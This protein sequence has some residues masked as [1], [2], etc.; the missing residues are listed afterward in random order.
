MKTSRPYNI[1]TKEVVGKM[2]V[3]EDHVEVKLDIPPILPPEQTQAILAR[4]LAERK[5]TPEGDGTMVRERGGV[6][7]SVDL[8]EEEMTVSAEESTEVKPPPSNPSPCSCRASA[9][10]QEAQRAAEKAA[11]TL[12]KRVTARL[13]GALA[14]LGCEVEGIIH[15]VTVEAIKQKASQL[16][17]IK[18]MTEDPKNGSL[19]IVVEV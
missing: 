12:Q 8:A 19:T 9:A 10:L 2:V 17:E 14:R 6:K 4:E 5:F 16:G 11:D 3:A 13:E 18:Q 7:V 15:R 1:E